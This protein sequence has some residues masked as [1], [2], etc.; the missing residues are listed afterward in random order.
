MINKELLKKIYTRRQAS[1]KR[2]KEERYLR[3]SVSNF[4]WVMLHVSKPNHIKLAEEILH[5]KLADTI[6]SLKWG[7]I[8]ENDAFTEYLQQFV[9]EN[10][11]MSKSGLYIGKSSF[12]GARPD[13]IIKMDGKC[14][15]IIE[16][17]CPY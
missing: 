12:L 4:G 10:N 14:H 16:I 6:P 8:H 9:G 1:C 17:K 3:L 5:S 13:G 2:R 15:K 11:T 7:R